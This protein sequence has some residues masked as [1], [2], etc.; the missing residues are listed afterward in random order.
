M[1]SSRGMLGYVLAKLLHRLATLILI[2]ALIYVLM[3]LAPGTPFDQ[4]LAMGK[5]TREQY[6]YLLMKWGYKDNIL[7]GLGKVIYG[8]FTLSLFKMNSPVWNQ[9]ILEL[10]TTRLI[11]TL[12]L[13]V[14]AYL[15]G[16]MLGMLLGLYTA[17]RHGTSGETMILWGALVYRSLPVFWLGMIFLY[18]LSYI[19]GFF[20]FTATSEIS[21]T[22]IFHYI[23]DW[24]WHSVLPLICLS[25]LAA[26]GYLFTIRNM[27]MD[28]MSNDYVTTLRAVGYSEHV[29]L[30][31]Y[32]MRHIMPP[33]IT[34]MAI[35]IGFLFG[36]AVV[37][38]TV[39]NYPGMG[40]LI[41]DAIWSKDYPVVLGA[42]YIVAL[43]VIISV[44]I[45]EILYAYLDPRIRA[46][47]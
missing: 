30:E 2:M 4:Y 7:V 29:I 6:E 8:M 26:V 38:E 1:S 12:G 40:R 9:P 45:A 15:L 32:V 21:P 17:R 14:S 39:F 47:R 33:V 31:R 34:M 10:I 46:T 16:S 23:V 42:F 36:G 24:F 25:K 18:F 3:R 20:P 43:A 41:Y 35:D 44:T 37:T 5:L 27:I 13:I 19:G 22:N 11:N 28:E